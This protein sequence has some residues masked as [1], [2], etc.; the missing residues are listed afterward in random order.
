MVCCE[1]FIGLYLILRENNKAIIM[2]STAAKINNGVILL[3]IAYKIQ[4]DKPIMTTSVHN[5]DM[6]LADLVLNVLISCGRSA[7]DII[8][9]A[10]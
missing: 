8:N 3:K 2:N 6:S 4:S 1:I 7:I 5:T 9:P 10:A